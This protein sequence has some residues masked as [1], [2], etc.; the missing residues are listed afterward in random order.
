M[1]KLKMK[2][3]SLIVTV[4]VF[5][6]LLVAVMVI[7]DFTK[8]DVRVDALKENTRVGLMLEGSRNDRSWGQSHYEAVNSLSD[9]LNLELV[10]RDN[11]PG[12][13]ECIGVMRELAQDGCRIIIAN[14]ADYGEYISTAAAEFPDIYFLHA[15]GTESAPNVA[16]F[17]GRMYQVRY[18]SGIIAGIQ[19]KTNSI[20]YVAAFPTSEVNRGIN[21]F[22]LGVRKVNPDA[23]VHVMFS[24]SWTDDTAAG[25]CAEKLILSYKTDVMTLH[26]NTNAPLETA[27]RHD[28]QVIGYNYDNSGMYP[29]TYLA[30]CVWNWKQFYYDE[31]LACINGRFRSEN[32][33]FDINS[34]IIGLALPEQTSFENE[35]YKLPLEEAEKAFRTYSFDVFYG[36][37][38]DN[39]GT[40]RIPAGE[41]MSDVNM[42][43]KFDWYVEGVEI[44]ER[45]Q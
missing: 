37:V 13:D 14:S 29:S 6:I 2:Q 26:T 22:T 34:D 12:T 42:L 11:V 17:F 39:T 35:A 41:S 40:I 30:G 1:H 36:P 20:G 43:N 16:T 7:L 18:L 3:I 21:A 25:E 5:S 31:I 9:V 44:D 32:K 28:V 19:T 8:G 23:V 15:A 24:D 45:A 10:C 38:T 27:D 33:W 4:T